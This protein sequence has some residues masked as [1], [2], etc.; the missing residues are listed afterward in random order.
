MEEKEVFQKLFEVAAQSKDPKG[1][2]SA[3]L[4]SNGEIIASAASSDDGKVHAENTLLQNINTVPDDAVLY[5]T[6]EPCSE[7]T[8]PTMRD[9]VSDII[10]FGV[11]KVVYGARDPNQSS[12]TQRRLSEAGVSL[13]QSPDAE[14]I[15]KSAEVF[16]ATVAD[17]Y[18]EEEVPR[19]PSD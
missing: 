4:V 16:N 19:K 6:I 10:E 5:S 8:D 9:C 17:H 1:V 2:V 12:E 13:M 11:K 3:C 15:R 7:R 14:I 18:S